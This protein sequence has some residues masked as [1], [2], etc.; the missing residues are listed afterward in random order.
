MTGPAVLYQLDA[1][2]YTLRIGRY[3]A[4]EQM[5]RHAHDEDG[6][7][8]IL[9]GHLVEEAEH[10]AVLVSTGWAV[11]KPRGVYHAN[12]FGDTGATILALVPRGELLSELPRRWRWQQSA[13]AFRA[14]LRFVRADARSANAASHDATIELVTALAPAKPRRAA[15][16]PAWLCGVKQALED[17]TAE[18]VAMLASQAGV[19]PVYLA[20][21]FRACYGVSLRQYRQTVQIRRAIQLL[22]HTRWPVGQIALECGFSDHSHM[23]RAF[24]VVAGWNPATLRR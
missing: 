12:R 5:Q 15:D 10:Q 9:D 19:H 13:A 23:C 24:R 17:L 14:A 21:A 16:A 3:A 2:D 4:G 22:L 1:D 8:I 7:S 6:V 18:S 11:V 20:R